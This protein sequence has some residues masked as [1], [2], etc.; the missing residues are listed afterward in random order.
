MRNPRPVLNAHLFLLS[1]GH[2]APSKETS[3]NHNIVKALLVFWFKSLFT[4]F[5]EYSSAVTAFRQTEA[6]ER[7]LPQADPSCWAV[8]ETALSLAIKWNP[9]YW[10]G[11]WEPHIEVG[12]GPVLHPSGPGP[13][14]R[15]SRTP[16][17]TYRQRGNPRWWILLPKS[18][19][20]WNQRPI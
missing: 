13:P 17:P 18:A 8:A 14:S 19:V 16:V 3:P 10:A 4:L 9:A 15:C 5:A 7:G 1:I 11:P 6:P 20:G 2:S 12:H